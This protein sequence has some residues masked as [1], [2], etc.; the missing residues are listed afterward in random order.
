MK[1]GSIPVLIILSQILL[2]S[3]DTI[4]PDESIKSPSALSSSHSQITYSQHII[5]NLSK[6]DLDELAA[7]GDSILKCAFPEGPLSADMLKIDLIADNYINAGTVLISDDEKYFHITFIASGGWTI[8]EVC[9]FLGTKENI[10]LDR[11]NV[12]IPRLF[13]VRE[14]F[15]Q[16]ISTVIFDITK[17]S[18]TTDCPVIL[19]NAKVSRSG[20]S[21]INAWGRGNKSFLSYF[22]R[23]RW[24][25][26]T[27]NI[28]TQK[29]FAEIK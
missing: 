16:G 14:K 1:A 15:S 2:P 18:S 17:N 27:D 25:Y 21:G 10:P 19:T 29:L 13:P 6:T 26:V 8:D 7:S 28:C 22:Y 12:P 9:L 5:A 3:C 4:V 23:K 20:Q 11:S 24:G